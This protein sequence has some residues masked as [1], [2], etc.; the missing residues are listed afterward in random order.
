MRAHSVILL[1]GDGMG[2]AQLTLARW[3]GERALAMDG[4][5]HMGLV[6]T[7]SASCPV[8]DS[9]AAATALACGVKTI[10]RRLGLDPDE[11][12]HTTVLER[13]RDAGKATGLVTTTRVTH[14]TPA[15]FVAAHLD[16]GREG[17]IAHQVAAAG[18]DLCVGGGTSKFSGTAR[19]ALVEA[20]YTIA[21]CFSEM[22]AAPQRKVFGL[23]APSHLPYE[24]ERAEGEVP[25][26]ATLTRDALSRLETAEDGFFLM[27]EGGRIDHAGHQHDAASVAAETLAFDDA[28]AVALGFAREREDV[29]VLTTADHAT[30]SL[31][32][33]EHLD[34]EGLR[35]QGA[36]TEGLLVGVNHDPRELVQQVKERCCLAISTDEAAEILA[37]PGRYGPPTALGHLISMRRGVTFFDVDFQDTHSSTHGHDGIAVPLF[38]HGPQAARFTE[39]L[40]NTEVHDRLVEAIDI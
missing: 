21:P 6:T 12:H 10:N 14:A 23:F 39:D 32:L 18:L 17:A 13:C 8:T 11:V 37:R 3:Y 30:G 20:G 7:P 40:D 5:P 4:F 31:G 9:A 33:S 27:V 29:L 26:L 28:V 38:A 36:S 19:Q 24:F 2:P 22:P 25:P 35:Q 16:R 34:L 1:I 15:A